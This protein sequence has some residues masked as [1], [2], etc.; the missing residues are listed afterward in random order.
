MKKSEFEFADPETRE[1][2]V[3]QPAVQLERVVK[4]RHG[5]TI[6][7]IA[8]VAAV[9]ALVVVGGLA[10]KPGAP[11]GAPP[12][13]S[14]TV[15]SP[16][17][18]GA[19]TPPGTEPSALDLTFTLPGGLVVVDKTYVAPRGGPDASADAVVARLAGNTY[20]A[21]VGRC[22]GPGAIAWEIRSDQAGE[23]E[24]GAVPCDGQTHGTGIVTF[25]GTELPLRLSYDSAINF[26]FVVTLVQG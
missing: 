4:G 26:R 21:V 6:G 11:P 15:G 18:A 13:T 7:T 12:A 16:A 8:G 9:V 19:P 1:A 23:V 24:S 3:P 25:S 14:R 17:E 5:R 2:V 10:G 20:Y 22:F